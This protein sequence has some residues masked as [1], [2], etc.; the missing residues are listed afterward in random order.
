MDQVVQS[1]AAQT[2]QL[3][4]TA[5]SMALQAQELQTLVAQFKV[6]T[7]STSDGRRL[8][9]SQYSAPAAAL[10]EKN[11]VAAL[12]TMKPRSRLLQ[13]QRSDQQDFEKL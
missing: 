5:Q 10:S 7:A 1:N 2:E 13:E 12:R 11:P 6:G 8:E 3:S 4:S 9:P